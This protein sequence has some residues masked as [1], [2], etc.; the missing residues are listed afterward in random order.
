M[1]Y[2][3][4]ASIIMELRNRGSQSSTAVQRPETPAR[5]S[6]TE[7]ES[8]K[9]KRCIRISILFS[10][11]ITLYFIPMFLLRYNS[12]ARD[13][14]V[15]VHHFKTPFFGNI[16][17]PTSFGMSLARQFELHHKDGC[18]IE[19]WQI[20]PKEYHQDKYMNSRNSLTKEEYIKFLSDSSPII[21]YL[22][23]N[24]G[25]RAT[26]HR[27]ELYRY[28]SETLGYHVIAFDYRGFGNSKCYPSERGM[29]EDAKLIWEW[30]RENTSRAKI[31]IWGHSLGS[32]AATYLT[33][34][35]CQSAD[36]PSGLI[37][38]APFT[39]MVDAAQNHPFSWPYLP[40]MPLFRYF[41][42][43]SFEDKFE[44]VDRMVYITCP[45]LI[46]HGESDRII[47]FLLGK[48]VYQKAL[49]S[50]REVE[51]VNCGSAGHK[52]S[53]E[54]SQAKEALSRFIKP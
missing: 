33:K 53:W 17:D 52:T 12:W 31:Y 20:L 30:L 47:P 2:G 10:T 23:G 8:W 7:R 51:F 6:N 24:T 48:Q 28:L 11:L 21:L 36:L 44:S 4:V 25:T 35:L 5:D 49:E 26:H 16:S 42:L 9:K 19:I 27:V 3:H 41:T 43:E 45:I 50:Q 37:L 40:I 14:V 22:H 46:L 15:F 13:A 38:E 54:S 32:A 18:S 34:D 29:M 39:N 1:H